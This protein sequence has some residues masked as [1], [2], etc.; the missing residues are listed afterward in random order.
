MAEAMIAKSAFRPLICISSC[1]TP[2]EN[3]DEELEIRENRK[4]NPYWYLGATCS[5]CGAKKGGL[6]SKKKMAE[7]GITLPLEEEDEP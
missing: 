4:G 5:E 7:M 6:V 1:R 2:T 3:L